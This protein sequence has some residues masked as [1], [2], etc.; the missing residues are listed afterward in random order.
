[1]LKIEKNN[2]F[3]QSEYLRVNHNKYEWKIIDNSKTKPEN[4]G[5]LVSEC[6][7]RKVN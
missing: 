5:K 2:F 6:K 4:N 7:K 3:G 1:M